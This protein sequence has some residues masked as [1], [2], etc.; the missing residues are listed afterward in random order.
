MQVSTQEV[1]RTDR[2]DVV[3]VPASV[4]NDTKITLTTLGLYVQLAHLMELYRP[5][6]DLEHLTGILVETLEGQF[7]TDPQVIRASIRYLVEAGHLRVTASPRDPDVDLT[8]KE[9]HQKYG[10]FPQL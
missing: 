8:E 10:G 2:P 6:H 5:P 4:I 3:V 7:A 1:R 9:W